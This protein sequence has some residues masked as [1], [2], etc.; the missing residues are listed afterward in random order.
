MIMRVHHGL[1]ERT[2]F[3][4]LTLVA[5]DLPSAQ[6]RIHLH[7]CIGDLDGDRVDLSQPGPGQPRHLRHE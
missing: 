1:V 7:R 4:W 5:R 3:L 2:A 6:K